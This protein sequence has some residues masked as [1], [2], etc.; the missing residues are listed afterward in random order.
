LSPDH[1]RLVKHPSL[2]VLIGPQSGAV[3]GI[4][5]HPEGLKVVTARIQQYEHLIR[6]TR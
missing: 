3:C 4:A 2:L 6:I 5:L 1:P